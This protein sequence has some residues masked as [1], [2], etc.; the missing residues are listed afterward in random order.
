MMKTFL[1]ASYC[2]MTAS[3]RWDGKAEV[4]GGLIKVKENGEIVAYYA[5]ESDAFKDYLYENCFFDAPSTAYE[6]GN[7]GTVYKGLDEEGREGYFF[8]LNFQIR[9]R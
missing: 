7:Y 9:Y 4:N 6:H 3:K 8:R 2:N 1:Y 5:L